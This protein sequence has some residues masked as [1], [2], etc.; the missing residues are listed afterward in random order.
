MKKVL[1]LLASLLFI[2]CNERGTITNEPTEFIEIHGK[3]YKLMRVT[4]CTGCN[5]I[6]IMY[7]K[8]SLD[9]QPQIINYNVNKGKYSV[10]ESVIKVD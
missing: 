9:S 3:V 2:S 10:N 6:W 1:F 8:D 7:P 4:P 5:S